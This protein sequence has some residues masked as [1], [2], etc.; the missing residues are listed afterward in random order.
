[1]IRK[2]QLV[3]QLDWTCPD[4]CEPPDL[5]TNKYISYFRL[6]MFYETMILKKKLF[7]GVISSE[8]IYLFQ[9]VLGQHDND[10]YTKI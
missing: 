8:G 5:I 1:M 3:E 2:L 6:T 10:V 7:N 9:Q 4:M